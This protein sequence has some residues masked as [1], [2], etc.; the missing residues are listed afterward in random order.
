MARSCVTSQKTH[1]VAAWMLALAPLGAAGVP[2]VPSLGTEPTR[3]KAAGGL[4]TS[5]RFLA[6]PGA[7]SMFVLEMTTFPVDQLQ[8]TVQA[9]I[10]SVRCPAWPTRLREGTLGLH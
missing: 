4:Q 8:F 9:P 6:L 2:G 5:W 10:W 1:S 7:S 3:L